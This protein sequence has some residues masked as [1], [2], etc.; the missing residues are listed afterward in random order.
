MKGKREGSKSLT[1]GRKEDKERGT[2]KE[3]VK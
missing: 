2:G 1:G 3:G